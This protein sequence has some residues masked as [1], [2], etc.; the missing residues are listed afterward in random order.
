MNKTTTAGDVLTRTLA[1]L[2]RAYL[3]ECRELVKEH[4][5][6]AGNMPHFK[7]QA[8]RA[9]LAQ[10]TADVSTKG[11]PNAF[12]RH[13]IVLA[14]VEMGAPRTAWCPGYALCG[15]AAGTLVL[16]PQVGDTVAWHGRDSAAVVVDFHCSGRVVVILKDG[17]APFLDETAGVIRAAA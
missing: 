10:I 9:V 5:A 14:W 8:A 16:V 11:R 7:A 1:T 3:K 2:R 4:P 17:R 12:K 6:Q 13:Q 15:L